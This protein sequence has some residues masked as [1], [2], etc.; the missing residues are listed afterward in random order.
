MSPRLR[1]R[2]RWLTKGRPEASARTAGIVAMLAN[3]TATTRT[4]SPSRD[5]LIQLI[6]IS[7]GMHD[8]VVACAQLIERR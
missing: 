1:A 8:D 7:L 3:G 6:E 2:Y 5:D 4:S